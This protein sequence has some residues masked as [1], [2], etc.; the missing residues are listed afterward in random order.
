MLD[1]H[2][3]EPHDICQE[4]VRA[5]AA[6]PARLGL[7]FSGGQRVGQGMVLTEDSSTVLLV[8]H[9]EALRATFTSLAPVLASDPAAGVACVHRV[10]LGSMFPFQVSACDLKV[11]FGKARL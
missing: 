11:G 3:A 10:K 9:P 2:L 4:G 1:A 5:R 6:E 8:G 7:V